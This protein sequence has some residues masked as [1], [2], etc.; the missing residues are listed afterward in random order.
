MSEPES[1][2]YAFMQRDFI[3]VTFSLS[4]I[5]MQWFTMQRKFSRSERVSSVGR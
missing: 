5:L 4:P 1:W 3:E 2:W